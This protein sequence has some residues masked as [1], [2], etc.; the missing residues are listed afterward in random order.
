[1]LLLVRDGTA[2]THI[3]LQLRI[4]GDWRGLPVMSMAEFC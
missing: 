2:T 1:M 3:E 4:S